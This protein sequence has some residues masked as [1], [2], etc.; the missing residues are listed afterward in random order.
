[1]YPLTS[2]YILVVYKLLVSLSG[3]IKINVFV[4]FGNTCSPNYIINVIKQDP[5]KHK[6]PKLF[7]KLLR[8]YCSSRSW[9]RSFYNC[10]L[11]FY[12]NQTVIRYIVL[13]INSH[14][15]FV[16]KMQK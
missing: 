10:Y 7:S 1:M 11:K 3:L 12:Q 8:H 9:F 16:N 15:C 5:A 6:I 2:I 4:R 13:L 14:K